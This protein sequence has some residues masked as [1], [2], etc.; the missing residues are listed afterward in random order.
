LL[1]YALANKLIHNKNA[2]L[3]RLQQG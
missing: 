3:A 1:K 2:T